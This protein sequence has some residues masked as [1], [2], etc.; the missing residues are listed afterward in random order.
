[1]LIIGQLAQL[2]QSIS[3]T[4]RGSGVR[5]P[6]CPRKKAFHLWRAFFVYFDLMRF[7]LYILH[8]RQL[9][10][11]YVGHTSNIEERPKS[12]LYNHL[13]FTS[14]A[15][16]WVLVYSE[17]FSKKQMHKPESYKLRNGK[18]D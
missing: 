13:G 4:P 8:S 18:V 9:N 1:M 17:E 15:K 7:Y 11:Y 2:V 6:H 5:I 10:K 14:K 12:H 3:F 16:D